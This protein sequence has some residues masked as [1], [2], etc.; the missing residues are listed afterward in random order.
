MPSRLQF[1]KA[2]KPRPRATRPTSY[3]RGYGG[4]EWESLRRS[5]LLRDNYQCQH[6]GKIVVNRWDGQVDHIRQ[7]RQGGEDS[8]DNLQTLCLRCHGRKT[9]REMRALEGPE[10]PF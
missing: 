3:R 10:T 6:C 1:H 9:A 5:V 8:L 7:K 2:S 4:K